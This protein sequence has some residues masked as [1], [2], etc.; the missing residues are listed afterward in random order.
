MYSSVQFSRSVVSDALQPHGLHHATLL[1]SSP[2]PG[3]C[4]NSCL[5]SWWCHPTISSSDIPFS[6]CLQSF[7]ASGS[8]SMSH[9]FASG[10]QST[11]SYLHLFLYLSII[12]I[13]IKYECLLI[14]LTLIYFIPF[15][16]CNFHLW[17]WEF[18]SQQFPF[19]NLLVWLQF[20]RNA[21]QKLLIYTLL[22]NNLSN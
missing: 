5:L 4:S 2:T 6:S 19:I 12:P 10:G 15:L 17:Q 14:S 8:F 18:D 20:K 13:S 3:A 1:C 22:R 11:Y 7:P 9:F 21:V 16:I